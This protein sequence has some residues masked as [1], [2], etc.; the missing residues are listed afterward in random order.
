MA[1]MK[2]HGLKRQRTNRKSNSTQSCVRL[3][4]Q[5]LEDRRLLVVGA[6]DVPPGLAPSS[7]I[8]GGDNFDGVVDINLGC[9]GSLVDRSQFDGQDVGG[10]HILTAAHCLIN[11]TQFLESNQTGTVALRYTG[12]DNPNAGANTGNIVTEITGNIDLSTITA[13]Q[14]QTK[15]EGLSNIGAGNVAVLQVG[16]NFQISFQN[17]INDGNGD[18]VQLLQVVNPA[19]GAEVDLYSTQSV[20][21]DIRGDDVNSSSDLTFVVEDM[22]RVGILAKA[23]AHPDYTGDIND[24][25]DIAMLYLS[26]VAPHEADAYSIQTTMDEVDPVNQ[27][28]Y[29]VGYGRTGTGTTGHNRDQGSQEVQRLT[30]TATSGDFQLRFGGNTSPNILDA[31]TVT[32]G[33]I[34]AAL[35]ALPG[36]AP[37]DIEVFVAGPAANPHSGS[38]EIRWMNGVGNQP[39]IEIVDISLVGGTVIPT[40]LVDNANVEHQL[41][42]LSG[43]TGGTFRITFDENNDG[44]VDASTGDLPFNATAQQVELALEAFPQF[45]EITVIES[46]FYAGYNL[47]IIFNS[48]TLAGDISTLTLDEANLSGDAIVATIQNGGTRTKR[49][50]ANNWSDIEPTTGNLRADFDDGDGNNPLGFSGLGDEEGLAGQGD[51]G[52][53]GFIETNGDLVVSGVVS[54]GTS[55]QFGGI[56]VYA[57]VS[58][59]TQWLQGHITDA[60]LGAYDL[61]LDMSGQGVGNDGFTDDILATVVGSQIEL[62]INNVLYYRDELA[63]ITSLTIA[64]SDDNE[65]I[66]IDLSSGNWIPDGGINIVGRMGDDAVVIQ[67]DVALDAEFETGTSGGSASLTV[68][69]KVIALTGI[70]EA[71]AHSFDKLTYSNETGANILLV[72]SPATGFFEVDGANRLRVAEFGTPFSSVL[73]LTFF[74][75]PDVIFDLGKNDSLSDDVD[76]IEFKSLS[77]SQLQNLTVNTGMGTDVLSIIATDYRLP[78]SGGSFEFNGGSGN[79]IILGTGDTSYQLSDSEL[80][81]SVNVNSKVLLDSVESARLVGGDSSNKFTV[82]DWSGAAELYGLNG[83]DSYEYF[84]NGTGSGLVAVS[85][86]GDG[87]DDITLTGTTKIDNVTVTNNSV[88]RGNEVLTYTALEEYLTVNTKGGND[89]IN[90]ESTA[91]TMIE[92]TIDGANGADRFGVAGPGNKDDELG[93][94]SMIEGKLIIRAGKNHP[95]DPASR[96]ELVLHDK[97]GVELF[98]YRIEPYS[99]T[100]L[101]N[102]VAP[103]RTFA[104]VYFD[105]TLEYVRVN[106]TEAV[107]K[108]SVRP[109]PNT[110]FHVD[111][112]EPCVGDCTLGGGDF[113]QLDLDPLPPVDPEEVTNPQVTFTEIDSEG[114]QRAGVW[115]FDAPHQDVE[116]ES[117]ERFNL[118][119]KVLVSDDAGANSVPEIDVRSATT[120]T[121]FSNIVQ[122]FSP[123]AIQAFSIVDFGQAQPSGFTYFTQL[124]LQDADVNDDLIVDEQ[125]VLMVLANLRLQPGQFDVRAD[126]DRDGK[127]TKLDLLAI[128]DRQGEEVLLNPVVGGVRTI[129]ADLNCDGIDDIIAVSGANHAPTV[130]AFNGVTGAAMTAPQQVGNSDN[131]FGVY[132]AAGDFDGDGHVELTTSMERESELIS[133]WEFVNDHFEF[134]HE[135]SSGFGN[136]ASSGVRVSA[137]DIDGDLIDEIIVSP[138]TGRDPEVRIFDGQGLQLRHIVVSSDY[139]R[140]GLTTVAADLNGDGM[141]EILILAGRRGGSLVSFV[142]GVAPVTIDVPATLLNALITTPDNLS[143]LSGIG[144]DMDGDGDDEFFLGQLSDGRLGKV[145]VFDWDETVQELFL[146]DEFDTDLNWTGDFLG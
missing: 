60:T 78:V 124:A 59:Y 112:N 36:I 95:A 52:G 101:V 71:V 53:P 129:A 142:S 100:N 117:I 140:G 91:A 7:F 85:D 88:T 144:R 43:A 76:A 27:A 131:R 39:E 110:I 48:V 106:G 116:F 121:S 120:L 51:S 6:F 32:A 74:D 3:E 73:P 94:L 146:L 102:T 22:R 119:D 54:G 17:D 143:P 18:S 72:D 108:F 38:F 118:L 123:G 67:G 83:D 107:N 86:S 134:S 5:V 21:F 82:A 31:A 141:D 127:V 66:E 64:G 125:D 133:V 103:P 26:V 70:T 42:E 13:A 40:T 115:T 89:I 68:G 77:A 128:L 114:R 1:S 20:F 24:G 55:T 122:N 57:R 47:E 23:Y 34:D 90:V 30:V 65:N 28:F 4:S 9:T 79:D 25:N 41:L 109:S 2:H 97:N 45:N 145:Q 16:T 138:G 49:I 58:S 111:G 63:Q 98:D 80:S 75:V 10:R 29:A 14:L 37:A 84:L 33:D 130:Q 35:T 87:V 113:L 62:W 132:V 69:S 44:I 50:A 99:V 12:Q 93:N 104:G 61:F 81:T 136:G 137:G 135:F 126:I 139:G 11:D 8:N 96:D 15:L 46:T 56:E 105:E 19:G 92:T